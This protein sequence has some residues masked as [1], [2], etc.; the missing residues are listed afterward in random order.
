[1]LV[2]NI[3]QMINV[4]N[5]YNLFMKEVLLLYAHFTDTETK[6]Q[7]REFTCQSHT[8]RKRSHSLHCLQ[9]KAMFSSLWHGSW[10]SGS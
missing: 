9:R 10:D 8:V 6:V 4:L 5:S 7:R 2:I 3:L 1:M